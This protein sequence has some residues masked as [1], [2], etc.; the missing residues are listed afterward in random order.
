MKLFLKPLAW[1]AATAHATFDTNHL[2]VTNNTVSYNGT[3]SVAFDSSSNCKQYTIKAEDTCLSVGRATNT[4][5]AQLLS[6]NPKLDTACS[7][8]KT[9]ADAQL[10]ISNPLGDYGISSNTHGLTT[11]ATT[12]AYV[13]SPKHDEMSS[14]KNCGEWHKVESGEDCLTMTA[15]YGIALKDFLFLNPMVYDNCTNLLAEVYYCAKPVGYVSDYLGYGGSTTRAP[16]KPVGATTLSQSGPL[17][18]NLA[19]DGPVIPLANGTRKDCYGYIDFPNVTDN[20]AADCWSLAMLVGTTSEELILWN[21]SLAQSAQQGK[22]DDPATSLTIDEHDYTYPCTLAANT[23]YCLVLSSPIPSTE[24]PQPEKPA[25]RAAGEIANCTSWALVH[26]YTT[27]ASIMDLYYL[28]I[29]TF[30]KMNP[31]IKSDCTGLA[32]GT[33]YCVSMWPGGGLDPAVLDD[34]DDDSYLTTT[35]GSS[36]PS[37]PSTP[38]PVQTGMVSGCNKF[39]KVVLGDGCYNIAHAEGFDLD[40]FYLWNP[41]VKNDCTGL[42]VNVYDGMV[43]DC[44][45]FYQV[46]SGD[47][48]WAIVHDANIDLGD[49]LKWNPAVHNDCTGLQENVHVCVGV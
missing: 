29:D 5:Y 28:D 21:P 46:K 34:D 41:A 11:V 22:T 24:P 2:A 20:Y 19:S 37:R 31:T 38:S 35:P 17:L 15:I 48:C 14:T 10:C 39:Y 18:G 27:C 25:P 40:D 33:F 32:A 4:T 43:D 7:N 42:Q 9:L 3:A 1:L 30:Y 47:G 36:T 8:L 12:A 26:D 44:A 13:P 23:S 6:W 45:K 16:I 49:F